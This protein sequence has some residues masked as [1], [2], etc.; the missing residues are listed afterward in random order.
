MCPRPSGAAGLRLLVGAEAAARKPECARC[1]ARA[2]A[3]MALLM[4]RDRGGLVPRQSC[5]A[6]RGLRNAPD[7]SR[8][9]VAS[10]GLL[11]RGA[12]HDYALYAML[13]VGS[14]APRATRARMCAAL[15][16]RVCEGEPS[17]RGRRKG[18]WRARARQDASFKVPPPA[19]PRVRPPSN[20][21]LVFS[22]EAGSVSASVS[23]ATRLTNDLRCGVFCCVALFFSRNCVRNDLRWPT[24]RSESGLSPCRLAK[25]TSEELRCVVALRKSLEWNGT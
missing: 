18:T 2:L 7:A 24:Q 23:S 5:D 17:Q 21:A 20:E 4:L 15:V 1:R 11:W 3:C 12:V 22:L 25:H 10:V 9:L 16:W 6:E 14:E 19:G 13:A 8:Q